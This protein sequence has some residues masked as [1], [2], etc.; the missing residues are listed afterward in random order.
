MKALRVAKLDGATKEEKKAIR[1]KIRKELKEAG[2]D[3][4]EI[5]TLI[6]EN[7]KVDK[8]KRIV[9]L[10]ERGEDVSDL[11][12]VDESIIEEG[13]EPEGISSEPEITEPETPEVEQ[14]KIVEPKITEPKE[15]YPHK[16][17]GG[18]SH[19]P[20]NPFPSPSSSLNLPS[21]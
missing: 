18:V 19:L 20:D 4:E 9:L 10:K 3:K 1:K 15:Y 7:I 21:R 17:S 2:L 12:T 5:K 14:P 13:A 16:I 6:K 8:E 11:E